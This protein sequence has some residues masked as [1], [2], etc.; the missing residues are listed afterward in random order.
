[1]IH[2]FRPKVNYELSF[3]QKSAIVKCGDKACRHRPRSVHGAEEPGQDARHDLS[4][5]GEVGETVI[6][7]IA[8]SLPFLV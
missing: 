3:G 4:E 5:V 1:M 8:N 2:H 6:F 7:A